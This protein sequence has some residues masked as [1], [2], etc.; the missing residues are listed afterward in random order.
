MSDEYLLHLPKQQNICKSDINV[1]VERMNNNKV[2]NIFNND[3]KKIVLKQEINDALTYFNELEDKIARDGKYGDGILTKSDLYEIVRSEEKFKNLREEYTS[4]DELVQDLKSTILVMLGL[5]KAPAEQEEIRL[6]WDGDSSIQYQNLRSGTIS[7][8]MINSYA[9]V[10]NMIVDG[11]KVNIVKILGNSAYVTDENGNK[12]N[13]KNFVAKCLNYKKDILLSLF[14]KG[15][16]T[17]SSSR[18]TIY[19]DYKEW[20]KDSQCFRETSKVQV[21]SIVR[22]DTL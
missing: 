1:S 7:Q 18:S 21:G 10:S 11:K 2:F 17:E 14:G 19:R 20:D 15:Y 16:Y 5:A 6:T 4:D 9:T 3:D 8:V 13:N 22:F 12:I